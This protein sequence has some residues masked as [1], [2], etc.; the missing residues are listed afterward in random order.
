MA[1][2]W[3][4]EPEIITL[5]DATV[6]T[7]HTSGGPNDVGA[8]VMKALCGAAYGLKFAL[9]KRG[10]EMRMGEP[11]ARWAWTPGQEFTGGMEGD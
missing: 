3:N 4:G 5:P 11:R 8:G 2:K 9:K 7:E 10:V 1:R 6:A